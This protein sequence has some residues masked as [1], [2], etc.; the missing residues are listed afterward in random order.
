MRAGRVDSTLQHGTLQRG[1]VHPVAPSCSPAAPSLTASV[2][3]HWT[4]AWSAV[5]DPMGTAQA[6]SKP[7]K[8]TRAPPSRSGV[9]LVEDDPVGSTKTMVASTPTG[10]EVPSGLAAV[11]SRTP[12]YMTCSAA[13]LAD[14]REFFL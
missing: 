10:E 8:D 3:A 4:V 9:A 11:Q 13:P 12:L 5:M 6:R 1:R 14:V 2:S 7:G